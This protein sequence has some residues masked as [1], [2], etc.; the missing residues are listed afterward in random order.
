M[1]ELQKFIY[2]WKKSGLNKDGFSI[3][4]WLAIIDYFNKKSL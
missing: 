1:E 4:M 2:H 3:E